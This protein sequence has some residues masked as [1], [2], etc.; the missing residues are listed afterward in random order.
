MTRFEPVSIRSRR[1]TP[2]AGDE[3][4]PVRNTAS[5]APAMT[6]SPAIAIASREPV[7]MGGR[8][9]ERAARI[10]DQLAAR[11]VA[12]VRFLRQRLP[13]HLLEARQRRRLLLEVRVQRRGVRPRRNRADLGQLAV[14]PLHRMKT[15]SAGTAGPATRDSRGRMARSA[16]RCAGK[17]FSTYRLKSLGARAGAAS[18]RS[19]RSQRQRGPTDLTRPACGPR[20]ERAPPPRPAAR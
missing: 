5:S 19:G 3:F 17:T 11:R 1:P 20:G 2:A 18:R 10:V 8:D 12:V 16:R 4:P 14:Q 13:K 6:A 15:P 7:A 9:P